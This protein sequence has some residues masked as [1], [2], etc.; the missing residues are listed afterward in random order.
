MKWLGKGLK[1]SGVEMIRH[2]N[3][4]LLESTQKPR[5]EGKMDYLIHTYSDFPQCYIENIFG[6]EFC[7]GRCRSNDPIVKVKALFHLLTLFFLRVNLWSEGESC[8]TTGR[9]GLSPLPRVTRPRG[10]ELSRGTSLPSPAARGRKRPTI[11]G[12]PVSARPKHSVPLP[13]AAGE[14]DSPQ[15]SGIS[16]VF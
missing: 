11:T 8:L 15:T 9:Q 10:T 3:G 2:L 12:V 1:Y 16:K 13:G 6:G 4:C 14:E 7:C 5:E